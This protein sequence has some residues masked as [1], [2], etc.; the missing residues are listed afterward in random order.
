VKLVTYD[1]IVVGLGAMGSAATYQLAKAG[2]EVLGIDQ[3][4]PPHRAGSTHGDTR[5]TRLAVGEGAHY[6]PLVSRSHQIW[7]DI[8]DELGC[9]LLDQRGA[10]IM[11]VQGAPGMHGVNDFLNQTVASADRYGID[12]E[13][14]TAAEIGRRFPQFGLVGTEDGYLEPAAGL[15]HPEACVEAQLGLAAK[16]GAALRRD[17]SVLSYTATADGVSDTTAVGSYTAQRLVVTVGPW[18]SDLLPDLA[19]TFSV[20]RQVMYWFD[21][22]DS[23]QYEAF[24]AMPVYIWQF[25]GEHGDFV[26]GFPMVDGPTGGAKIATEQYVQTTSPSKVE[27]A[28]A[29]G[30]IDAMYDRYVRDRL[31]GLGKTCLKAVSCLYTV[32]ADGGFVIDVHPAHDNV[33]VASPCSGHGFKHSAAIGEVLSQLAMTGSCD[34]DISRFAL[35]RFGEA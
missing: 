29:R 2:A 26:Y 35:A 30:E 5:I 24:A 27:R 33:I 20:Y 3:Y 34:V 14:L 7:R 12:H 8:E 28:V 15:L 25:S 19:S 18:I 1:V 13:L 4:S 10:L 11:A 6:V 9:Q 22:E 23:S 31:P 21:L 17:E 16:H 32:T